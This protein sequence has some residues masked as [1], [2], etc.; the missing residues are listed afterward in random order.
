MISAIMEIKAQLLNFIEDLKI[1]LERN[2]DNLSYQKDLAE[3]KVRLE[4]EYY[5]PDTE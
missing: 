3:A 5:L 2:P 4:N 1:Q